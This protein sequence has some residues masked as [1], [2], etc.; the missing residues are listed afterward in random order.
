VGNPDYGHA[1]RAL[2]D[3]KPLAELKGYRV[4]TQ[5]AGYFDGDGSV[6]LRTDSPVV[7]R[8]ALVWVDNCF[9][10]LLQ[11]KSFLC[12]RGITLGNVLQQGIG[13]FSLL[14]STSLCLEIK[15]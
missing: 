14:L 9:E 2:H 15:P 4:W 13:V 3:E 11:P 6:H 10:Q 12:S 5:V 8:F 7:L 1:V